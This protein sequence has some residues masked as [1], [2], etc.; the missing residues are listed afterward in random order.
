MLLS[1]K[2]FTIFYKEMGFGLFAIMLTCAYIM[3]MIKFKIDIILKLEKN[4]AL[5][6]SMTE[7]LLCITKN[8]FLLITI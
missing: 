7:K 1:H 3:P 5:N 8:T 4:T 2:K 6:F